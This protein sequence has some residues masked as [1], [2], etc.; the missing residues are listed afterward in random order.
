MLFA[1]LF[2][3]GPAGAG[4]CEAGT[5]MKN[6]SGIPNRALSVDP[7]GKHDGY[8]AVLYDNRNG[9]PTSEAN[10]IVQT[11]DGF[12]WIGSY[13]GLIRYDGNTF[14]RMDST[15]GISSI[16]CLYADSRDR[17]WIGTNDNGIAVMER[18]EIRMWGKADG[19]KS[20]HIRAITEDGSGTVYIATTCGIALID[21]EGQLRMMED[22]P[23]A[24]ANMRELRMGNDGIIYGTTNFGDLLRIRDG[25]LINFYGIEDNP[26]KGAG[27]ILPDPEAP[28]KIYFEGADFRFYHARFEES[29]T[30]IEEIDISPLSYVEQ[31]EYID[32]SVWICTSYGIGVLRKDGFHT[33]EDLPMNNSIA[34]VITDESGNLWFTSSRQ[35]VM[36]VVANQFTDLFGQYG[37]AENVVNTTCMED[38]KLFIGTDT[39]LIVIGEDGPVSALP[40]TKAVTASGEDLGAE[41]LV[42]LL[43]GCRIRS[44]IRDSRGRLWIS[45]WRKCGLLRYEKGEVLAFTQEDGL[46]SNGIRAICER[47]DGTI[48]VALVGGVNVIEGDRIIAGY[49]EKDGITN[50]ESL[51]VSE[52]P[53]GD[54]VIG[55][56]GG[57]IYVIGE[58]GLWTIN[59]EDGLPS[60]IVMRLKQDPKRDVTWIVTSNAIAWMTPDYQVTTV[61]KFPYTNN[62]DLVEN[63]QGDMWVLSSNGIYVASAEEML[64]NGEIH[65]VFYSMAN[66]LPCSTTA[67]SYSE[68]TPEGDLYIAGSTCACKVNIEKPFVSANDIKAAVPYMEADG[69]AIYPDAPGEFTVPA[70]TR[71]LTVFPYVLNYSL[72]NPS[73]SYRLDGFDKE[74]VTVS[75]SELGPVSYTNLPNGTYDFVIGVTDPVARTDVSTSFRIS[76]GKTITPVTVGSIV[77]NA[78]AIG[79]LAGLLF[80][81]SLNRKRGRL[82]DRLFLAMIAVNFVQAAADTVFYLQEKMTLPAA[83]QLMIAEGT[84]AYAAMSLFP[85][86][87]FLYIDYRVRPDPERIR[88]RAPLYGIP[89]FLFLLV[90]LINMK[91][92]WLFSVD[93]DYVRHIGPAYLTVLIP[94]SFY[95]LLSTIRA[96]RINVR[97]VFVAI[98][99]MAFLIL[100][101]IWFFGLSCTS[102]VYTMFLVCTHIHTMN[103]PLTEEGI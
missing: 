32:G 4:F 55:S 84:V 16:K 71:K 46:L 27:P 78:T 99:I 35:G 42:K 57:G 101:E 89:C 45:T 103:R 100:S 43:D 20:A 69:K 3:I 62:F 92:G 6:S 58:S 14:E 30:E 9:L 8:S 18:G 10:A 87:F 24:E 94:L 13:A 65:T 23:I 15:G 52:G 39:G 63:S 48:L 93:T 7:I 2:V 29:L 38:G 19:M 54:I 36:K 76:K 49:S 5:E 53:N 21:T 88:K 102:F 41:D 74:D 68:L 97:L 51:T 26:A 85:Y 59:V 95:F 1:V 60:D 25:K 72:I 90:V 50:T 44:I 98:L 56:N 66:G 67:N 17:L 33:A 80:Y 34:H 79:F 96:Y 64:E 70:D 61:R 82:D 11:S 40:L 75:R 12:I 73:V 31:M 77:M 81:T 28:G 37:L 83:R 91:T 22:G 47:K 86:L